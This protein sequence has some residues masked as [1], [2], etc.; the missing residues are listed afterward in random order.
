MRQSSFF[1]VAF[2]VFQTARQSDNFVGKA[3]C[4]PRSERTIR[5]R[6]KQSI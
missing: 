1:G 6:L 5:H 4:H 3:F 2:Q